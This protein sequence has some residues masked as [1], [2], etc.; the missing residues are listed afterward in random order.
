[1]SHEFESGF[2]VRKPAWHGLGTVLDHAPSV[3][4]GIRAA[5]LD[6]TVEEHP[7]WVHDLAPDTP[8]QAADDYKAIVRSTDQRILSVVRNTWTPLQNERAFTFFNPFL[9]ENDCRLEAAGSLKEGRIVWV[10]AELNGGAQVV[11]DDRVNNYLLLCNSHDGSLAVWIQFTAVR[12]VCWNTLSLALGRGETGTE[13]LVRIRHR[14]NVEVALREVQQAI[15]LS[16]KTFRF[17]SVRRF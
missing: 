7:V 11:P 17:S 9:A 14:G 8:A 1:M 10:L 16:R 12:V 4:E 6:W 13:N 3:E 5:G 2:F 15:E